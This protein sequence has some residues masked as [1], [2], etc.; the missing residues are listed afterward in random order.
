MPRDH[1]EIFETPQQEA[2]R[3]Y[4]E[5]ESR[6]EAIAKAKELAQ[7]LFAEVLA[8]CPADFDKHEFSEFCNDALCEEIHERFCSKKGAKK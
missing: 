1:N 5:D 4:R 7:R 3:L 2:A 6:V 8:A